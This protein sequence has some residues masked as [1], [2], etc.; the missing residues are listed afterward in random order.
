VV[1]TVEEREALQRV[2]RRRGSGQAAVMRARIVLA[3]DAE[4]DL[5]NGAIAARPGG[6]PRSAAAR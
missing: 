6:A 3:A 2:V 5:P 1:L 4:P